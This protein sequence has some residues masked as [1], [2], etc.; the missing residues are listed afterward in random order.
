MRSMPLNV[1]VV[2]MLVGLAMTDPAAA[3]PPKCNDQSNQMELD[4]CADQAFEAADTALNRTYQE[5]QKRLAGDA[6]G[7]KRISA[8]QKAWISFRDAECDFQTYLS[9][10]GSIYPMLVSEC[11]TTLTKRRTEELKLYLNCEEGDLSCPVP[12]PAP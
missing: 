5:I 8:A 7:K 3:V 11:I 2:T 1:A 10:D 4:I 12:V 6:D 9:K